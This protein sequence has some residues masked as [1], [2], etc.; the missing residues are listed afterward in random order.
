MA[1]ADDRPPQPPELAEVGTPL[2]TAME[3][4]LRHIYDLERTGDGW[5]S[6][7]A[8]AERLD[9]S[10][11][12]VTSMFRALA[13][14]DLIEHQRY[15]PVRLTAAGE[16]VALGVVRRHRLAEAYLTDAF[17]YA[18]DE[19]DAEA[20]TLEHH[21]S[22]RLCRAIERSLD[23]P[24]YDPHG[25]PI[26]DADLNVVAE[27]GVPLSE[28]DEGA[29]VDVT[30]LLVRDD[31]TLG[32]L[33]GAD[34]EPSAR[35]RVETQAPFGM[36]TVAVSGQDREQSLPSAIASQVLVTGVDE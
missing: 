11:P 29:V 19:V 20:D 24:R 25:D 27:A 35:L 31:E 6:N 8:L 28:V 12:T 17:G 36:V 23:D 22:D 5:V 32:Y 13:E 15:R 16:Q 3:D 14:R 34:I 18:L 10:Q 2:T 1:S 4:A 33:L 7:S 21:M 30:R 26:P 9:V